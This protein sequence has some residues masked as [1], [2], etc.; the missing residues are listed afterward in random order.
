MTGGRQPQK[1]DA[2]D[3]AIAA[4]SMAYADRNE[5]DHTALARAVRESKVKA[6]FEAVR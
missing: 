5:K 4:F 6:A 3:R 2:F 1:R